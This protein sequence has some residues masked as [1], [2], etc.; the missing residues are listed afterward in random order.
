MAWAMSPAP[1]RIRYHQRIAGRFYTRLE[2]F[3]EGKPCRAY[4]ASGASPV[5]DGFEID[6]TKLFEA[7]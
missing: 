2:M 1:I 4:I 6:P 7:D 3:L 5:L